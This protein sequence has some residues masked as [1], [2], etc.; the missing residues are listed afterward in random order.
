MQF[1]C[2][3]SCILRLTII[4]SEK[5]CTRQEWSSFYTTKILQIK[6][7]SYPYFH[8]LTLVANNSISSLT[9]SCFNLNCSALCRHPSSNN[10]TNISFIRS[11]GSRSINSSPLYASLNTAV[12]IPP[13]KDR[14][15]IPE[16]LVKVVEN[17]FE[18]LSS[19][20]RKV[21]TAHGTLQRTSS[22]S[23]QKPGPNQTHPHLLLQHK[24]RWKFHVETRPNP[25]PQ[26]PTLLFSPSLN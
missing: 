17:A 14:Q 11:R 1:F 5:E 21:R 6:S 19:C 13:F 4:Q 15:N 8:S 2:N 26:T 7:S 22:P 10:S 3:N 12:S 18:N 24:P 23:L 16:C 25:N 20:A 9:F